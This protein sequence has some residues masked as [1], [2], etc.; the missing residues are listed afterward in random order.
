MAKECDRFGVSD[1]W[2]TA[3]ATALLKD[4]GIVHEIDTSQVIDRNKARR[5]RDKIR[6]EL[7]AT[8]NL[9]TIEALYFDS[10][11]DK[12]RVQTKIG[13]KFYAKTKTHV[14]PPNGTAQAILNSFLEYFDSNNIIT[15]KLSAI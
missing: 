5:S 8:R 12:T 2:A 9:E 10:R 7:V 13:N 15:D 4:V 14:T 11:K 3:V 6:N 1:R